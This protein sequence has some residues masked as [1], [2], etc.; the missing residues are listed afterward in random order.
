[1]EAMDDDAAAKVLDSLDGEEHPA[2]ALEEMTR[3]IK[4]KKDAIVSGDAVAFSRI[5]D[6]EVKQIREL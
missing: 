3:S 6:D 4:Q 2:H 5:I 1:M